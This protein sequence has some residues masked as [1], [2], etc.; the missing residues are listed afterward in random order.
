[1]GIS[2]KKKGKYTLFHTE[3]IK[4]VLLPFVQDYTSYQNHILL[5]KRSP[6]EKIHTVVLNSNNR[7]VREGCCGVF[8]HCLHFRNTR[9]KQQSPITQPTDTGTGS[10][11]ISSITTVFL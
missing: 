1:M 4:I 6:K 7:P 10:D 5:C 3:Q 11:L 9:L 8:M 2:I